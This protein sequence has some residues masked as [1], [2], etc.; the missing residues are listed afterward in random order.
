MIIIQ[1]EKGKDIACKEWGI[2]LLRIKNNEV[3]GN[4]DYLVNLLRMG[5]RQASHNIKNS[6]F[7]LK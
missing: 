1:Y 6:P 2:T 7:A 5:W 3:F 4:H